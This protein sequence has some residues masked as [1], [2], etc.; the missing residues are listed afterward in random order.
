MQI[1]F[2]GLYGVADER[3]QMAKIYISRFFIMD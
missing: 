1:S 2:A 3:F